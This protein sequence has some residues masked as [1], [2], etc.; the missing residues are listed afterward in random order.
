MS[1]VQ[2]EKLSEAVMGGTSSPLGHA[3]CRAVAEDSVVEK[4]KNSCMR[5]PSTTA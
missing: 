4:K 5:S 1:K 2:H 3:N